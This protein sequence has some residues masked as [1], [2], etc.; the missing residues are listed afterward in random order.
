M[1]FSSA[2]CSPR[3]ASCC[4]SSAVDSGSGGRSD[5]MAATSAAERSGLPS[6]RGWSHRL[7]EGDVHTLAIKGPY[8]SEA[9]PSHADTGTG[10]HHEQASD[11]ELSSDAGESMQ[12]VPRAVS[13]AIRSSSSV[14]TTRAQDRRR[15]ADASCSMPAMVGVGLPG[16]LVGPRKPSCRRTM[17]RTT[18]FSPMPPV[19]ISASSRCK[20]TTSPAIALASRYAKPRRRAGPGRFPPRPRLRPC[21]CRCSPRQP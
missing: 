7:D 5:V 18:I 8:Q 6:A 3:S 15:K 21:A 16:V 2:A 1:I 13:R 19:K 11:H 12:A 4:S 14:G 10:R 9:R 20:P 17:L